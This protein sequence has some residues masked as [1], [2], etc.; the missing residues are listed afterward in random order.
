MINIPESH[1][2]QYVEIFG[3]DALKEIHITERLL[4][5][6]NLE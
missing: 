1:I 6:K 4:W 3:K 5:L 2:D